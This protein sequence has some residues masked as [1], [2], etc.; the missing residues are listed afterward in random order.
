MEIDAAVY[1]EVV[2]L[3]KRLMKEHVRRLLAERGK[4]AAVNFA[5]QIA[6]HAFADAGVELTDECSVHEDRGMIDL[7]AKY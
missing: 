4:K 1:S 5:R 7:R 6:R 3:A 2:G